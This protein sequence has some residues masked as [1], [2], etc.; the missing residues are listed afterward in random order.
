MNPNPFESLNHLTVPL[1]MITSSF[2]KIFNVTNWR[3][4]LWQMDW[5]FREKPSRRLSRT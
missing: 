4:P 3:A 5:S 1:V 2:Q